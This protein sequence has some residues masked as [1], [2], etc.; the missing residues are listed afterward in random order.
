MDLCRLSAN[1]VLQLVRTNTITVEDYAQALLSRIDTRNSMVKAWAYLDPAY[2]LEQ[3]RALDRI[4]HGQ[5]GPLHGVAIGIK[6]VMET[7]DMPTEYQSPLYKGFRSGNDASAVA[8]LRDAG[9]LIFGKTTTS[10][11]TVANTHPSTANPH[12]PTRT[13]G[14]SSCGSAAA[15]ADFQVPIA[16]GAQTG[17]SLIRPASFTGV[18]AMKATHNAINCQ[19]CKAFAPSFDTLGFLAR[20]MEDLKLLADVFA[21]Q[22]DTPPP[23]ELRLETTTVALMKTPSWPRAGPGTIAALQ[24]AVEILTGHGVTVEE[25]FLPPEIGNDAASLKQI[26]NTIMSGEARATFL[27]EYRMDKDGHQLA[28]EIRQLVENSGKYTH[29]DRLQASDKLAAM[30]P[31]MDRLA[32]RYSVILAPSAIDEAP[33]GLEDMG[34][35]AFNIIWTGFHMPVINIPAFKGSHGMPIG[36]S[37]VAGRFRDQH[38]LSIAKLL[39]GPLMAEGGWQAE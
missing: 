16:L 22:D 27:R 12:D 1:Q 10:E 37:L 33:L 7:K 6:D 4:P 38:L 18:F 14:G 21:L 26:H 36:V 30:R 2:V 32:A 24:K 28:P 15:V 20:S 17:G 5:R 3:A 13:P 11:F 8:I 23:S 19:G 31:I 29:A 25:V 39:A 9:A 35:P 34:S